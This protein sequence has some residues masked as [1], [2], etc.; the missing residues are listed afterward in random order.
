MNNIDIISIC[1]FFG[2]YINPKPLLPGLRSI[3]AKVFYPQTKEGVGL[4]LFQGRLQKRPKK[5]KA[6]NIHFC[7]VKKLNRK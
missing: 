2:L 4:K 5:A 3:Q 1:A 7:K 6:I